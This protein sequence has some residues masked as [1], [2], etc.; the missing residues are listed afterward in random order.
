MKIRPWIPALVLLLLAAVATG[1]WLWTREALAPASQEATAH[2]RPG[3]A[4]RRGLRRVAPVQERLVDQS[5]LLT[6]RSLMPL[7]VTQE[8]KQL[9]LQAERLGNHSVDL[10]FSDALRRA[11]TAQPP[12]TPEI[13]D[14]IEA[15]AKAQA[16]VDADQQLVQ[17]LA[18]QLAG[19]PESRKDALEDQ[20]EVAKAQLELDKDELEAAA[21]DLANAGGD[22]QAKIKRLKEAHEAADRE[23]SQ[24]MAAARPASVFQPGSLVGRILEWRSQ[25]AKCIR[26]EQARLEAETKSQTLAKR[27]S[28][29]EAQA[30]KEKEDREAA[31]FW[32]ANLVKESAA[33]GVGPGGIRPALP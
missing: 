30:Q 28:E 24:A 21:N 4:A 15:K 31:K 5:P 32:A 12:Q 27:R 3:P 25:R 8:E 16:A 14:L 6:A 23:S 26:L 22:P 9:A 33:S 11:A 19:A 18:R 1:G 29:I 7:A 2:E 13:K 20:T 10:A 17:R